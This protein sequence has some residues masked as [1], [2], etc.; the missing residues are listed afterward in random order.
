MGKVIMLS[1]VIPLG[2]HFFFPFNKTDVL[3][4]EFSKVI[5]GC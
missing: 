2:T 4:I 1:N 3:Q 5:R